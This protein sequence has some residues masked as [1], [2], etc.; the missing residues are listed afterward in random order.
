MKKCQATTQQGVRCSRPAMAG[1]EYC[2][3]HNWGGPR[4]L[5]ASGRMKVGSKKVAPKKAAKK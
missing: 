4:K 3:Q 5:A 1:S 2:M